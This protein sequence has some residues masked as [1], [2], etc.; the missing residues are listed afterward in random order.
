MGSA[1]DQHRTRATRRIVTSALRS[2]ELEILA[3]SIEQKLAGFDG[4]FLRAPVDFEFDQFFFHKN[5]S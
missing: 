5:S 3:Q 1:V 2:G 4:K